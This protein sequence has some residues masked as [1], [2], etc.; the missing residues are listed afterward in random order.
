MTR[1]FICTP[2]HSL[3][4]GVER[5]VESLAIQLPAR[6]FE[7]TF[8]LVKGARYQDPEKFR[9]AF[10]AI[11]GVEV[12]GTSGSAYGRRRALRQAIVA[13]DPDVV[14][15]ARIF[16]AYPVCAE[17]KRGG[18]RLRLAV[19]VQAYEWEYL[20]DLERYAA[21]VDLCVTSGALIA[22]AVTRFTS[23]PTECVL[24]I[25]GG[26]A[27]AHRMRKPSDGPLRIGY[28][29]RL[30]QVQKRALDLPLLLAELDRRG[31]PFACTV[32]GDGSAAAELRARM[33][34]SRFLGWLSTMELY[35]RVYP[36]IDVLVHFAEWEGITIAPREAMVHGV[37]PVVSRFTG[38]QAEEQFIDGV[39]SLT[40]P[41]GDMA[42][43][44]EAIA[45]LHRDRA[46]LDRLSRAARDSQD[47]IRSEQ[48]AADAWADAFRDALSRPPRTGAVLP[49]VP[50]DHGLLGRLGVPDS[51][52]E[53]ARRLRRRPHT[54]PGSEWPHW[55]GVRNEQ[56]VRDVEAFGRE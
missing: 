29:G 23:V 10:P 18:Q 33:P 50:H 37:I 47:G 17:L 49:P 27:S 19:T 20:V 39:N 3:Q 38:L 36:E 5:I 31:I 40:F 11:R 53:I 4:G 16:D 25:P 15:I 43:A 51:I 46:M 44:A 9:R 13:A 45:R 55:S 21:F 32:A 54:D 52:A 2:T 41:V 26:V 7:V 24:N 42:L 28:V 30:E 8:G 56:L 34:S 35:D 14:L 48:G 6:G 1:L 12:D 22:R